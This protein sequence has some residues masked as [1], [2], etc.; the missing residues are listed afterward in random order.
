MNF[1]VYIVTMAL[2][3]APDNPAIHGFFVGFVATL[4]FIGTIL[5]LRYI[6]RKIFAYVRF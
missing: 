4:P 6:W 5:I 1:S 3:P 2:L